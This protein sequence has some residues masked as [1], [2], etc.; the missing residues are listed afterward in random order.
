MP[1]FSLASKGGIGTFGKEAYRFVDFLEKSGQSW[2]QILPLCPT[3]YG[4]SPYQS[5]SSYA[6]NP[7]FIDPEILIQE[8]LLTDEEF[9]AFDFGDDDKKVDYG[10]LYQNRI[11]MLKKAYSRF[12][13]NKAYDEFCQKNKGWLEEYVLFM[14]LKNANDDADWYSWDESLRLRKTEALIKAKK[15]V[16]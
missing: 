10:K 7:Y 15:T 3:N 6:G 14:A 2:W 8:E 1:I 13:P 12:T 9:A 5:F 4:D 16:I 11:P